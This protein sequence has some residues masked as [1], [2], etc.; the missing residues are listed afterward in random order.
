MAKERDYGEATFGRKLTAAAFPGIHGAIAAK[1]GN[2]LNVASRQYGSNLLGSIPGAAM[3][4]VGVAAKNPILIG[5]GEVLGRTGGA[6]MSVRSTNKSQRRGQLKPQKKELGYNVAK[7]YDF[8]DAFGVERPDII[9]KS[10]TMNYKLAESGA[11]G[12]ARAFRGIKDKAG[13]PKFT[14]SREKKAAQQIKALRARRD[15]V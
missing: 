10:W 4:G 12:T 15:F 2:K 14:N 13:N 9:E 11:G 7:S 1:K 8:T 3:T 5:G 6:I